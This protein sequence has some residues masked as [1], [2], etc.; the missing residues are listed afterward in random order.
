[1]QLFSYANCYKFSVTALPSDKLVVSLR[2][3]AGVRNSRMT[4]STKLWTLLVF[5]LYAD[6]QNT[7]NNWFL[8]VSVSVSVAE[9]RHRK[10]LNIIKKIKRKTKLQFKTKFKMKIKLE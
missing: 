6:D 3:L 4:T 5:S 1:M 9:S 10:F 7:T 8:S 2:T